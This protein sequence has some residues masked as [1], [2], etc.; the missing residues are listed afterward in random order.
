LPQNIAFWQPPSVPKCAV[1]AAN[2]GKI[3]L[4]LSALQQRT[5]PRID[6]DQALLFETDNP[7][8]KAEAPPAVL[9]PSHPDL[10][11]DHWFTLRES[12]AELYTGIV[13]EDGDEYEF[14]STGEMWAGVTGT[15]TH[16]P[17]GWDG[18]TWD[19]RFPL[20]GSLDPVHAHPFCVLGRFNGGYFF[21]GQHRP[22][23]RYLKLEPAPIRLR[24]NDPAPGNG[25][26]EFRVRVRVWG[27]PRTPA[28]LRVTC[29]RRARGRI[30]ELGGD[31][32]G[33]WH[34][35]NSASGVIAEIET[36]HVYYVQGGDGDRA[37]VIV[38]IR[39]GRKYLTTRRGGGTGNNLSSL[40]RCQA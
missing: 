40:P 20:Y 8:S 34:W 9:P 31:H 11:A 33:G 3:R 37:Q 28:E 4:P 36:G 19:A 2:L 21:I 29:V 39:N 15:G 10:Q 1:D 25:T 14:N 35:W 30:V 16:G 17:N 6:G 24:V 12:T 26:G 38:S 23:E 13:L 18:I 32:P 7:P 27:R 5:Q 22:R